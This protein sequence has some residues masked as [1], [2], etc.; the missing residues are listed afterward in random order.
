MELE[1]EEPRGKALFSSHP[2]KD[3]KYQRDIAVDVVLDLL[4]EVMLARLLPCKGP[5]FPLS[6]L[7]SL[8]GNQYVHHT[9]TE[10]GVMLH[11]FE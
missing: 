10:W 11:L 6:I 9:L 8:G 3:T 2:V 4:A 1:E 7:C 5:L